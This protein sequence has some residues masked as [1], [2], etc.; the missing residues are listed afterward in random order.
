M[1]SYDLKDLKHLKWKQGNE[2]VR[3]FTEE[4]RPG[5]VIFF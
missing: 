1:K 3:R 5:R 4:I 2:E